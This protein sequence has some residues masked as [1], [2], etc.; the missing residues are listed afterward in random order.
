MMRNY[1]Y[2][3]IRSK[4]CYSFREIAM[5]YGITVRTVRRWRR[6]GLKMIDN[7]NKPYLI[8]GKELIRFFKL[9]KE[10]RK[11]KLKPG[12]FNCLRCGTTR[13][14]KHNEITI[15]FRKTKFTNDNRQVDIRGICEKCN[16]KLSLFSSEKR[17]NEMINNG[18][19]ILPRGKRLISSEGHPLNAHFKE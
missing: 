14:S 12:Q 7:N 6:I 16:C 13:R 19:V 4:R 2:R 3:L 5:I 17:L 11:I 8:H 15:E 10:K 1:N 9:I 18:Q